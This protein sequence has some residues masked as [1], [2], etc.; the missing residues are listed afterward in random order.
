MLQRRALLS[1]VKIALHI[2]GTTS[3]ARTSPHCSASWARQETPRRLLQSSAGTVRCYMAS[4]DRRGSLP[5]SAVRTQNA[6]IVQVDRIWNS[7]PRICQNPHCREPCGALTS[8]QHSLPS[9]PR[10]RHRQPTARPHHPLPSYT[11]LRVL[12]LTVP[13]PMA[14]WPC[15]LMVVFSLV[16]LKSTA[17]SQ[18]LTILTKTIHLS[19]HS[20]RRPHQA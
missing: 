19:H 8:R 14:P 1:C 9:A 18:P 13:S 7:I 3:L 17:Y 2:I 12:P 15:L 4:R 16:S 10:P 6:L 11:T 20:H 5:R